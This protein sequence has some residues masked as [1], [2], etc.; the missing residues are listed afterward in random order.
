MP[1][2]PLRN[3]PY[4]EHPASYYEYITPKINP[5]SHIVL[6]IL[7]TLEAGWKA[8]ST[9]AA[10]HKPPVTIQIYYLFG[11]YNFAVVN[12]FD[13]SLR[14]ITIDCATDRAGSA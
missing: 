3:W 5:K 8:E 13:Y 6:L 4:L 12:L 14:S 2:I 11:D 9:L 10:E 1:I 7:P